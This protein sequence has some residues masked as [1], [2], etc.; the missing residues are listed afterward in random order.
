MKKLRGDYVRAT[1]ATKQ[2]SACR[3]HVLVS[4]LTYSSTLKMEKISSSETLL[5]ITEL[6]LVTTLKVMGGGG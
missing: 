1:L 2:S 4:Y 6:H 5:D 3:L